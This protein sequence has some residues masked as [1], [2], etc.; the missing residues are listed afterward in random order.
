MP[1]FTAD[2]EIDV[3]EFWENCSRSEKDEMINM[4]E[5]EGWVRRV[6]PDGKNPGRYNQS[7]LMDNEWETMVRNL[8][9]LRQRVT[10][11]EEEI[12]KKIVSRYV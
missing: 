1:D 10:L 7:S 2:I 5:D 9:D 4:L 6:I 11:E 12:I 8:Y 3:E